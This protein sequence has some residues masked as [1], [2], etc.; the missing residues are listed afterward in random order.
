MVRIQ[1]KE[2]KVIDSIIQP[3]KLPKE[4]LTSKVQRSSQNIRVDT[5][6]LPTYPPTYIPTYLPTHPS[7]KEKNVTITIIYV[8]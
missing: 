3:I 7:L 4:S 6:H 1:V 5:I 8:I 2:D